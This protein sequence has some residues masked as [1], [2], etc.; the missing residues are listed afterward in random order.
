[1]AF[2]GEDGNQT[3]SFHLVAPCPGGSTCAEPPPEIMLVSAFGPITAM[4]C[5]FARSSGNIPRSFFNSTMLCSAM[6]RE[7]SKPPSTSTTLFLTGSSTIPLANSE[8]RIRSEEHTSELQSRLHLVCRLLLE[9][10]KTTRYTRVEDG[11]IP[12]RFAPLLPL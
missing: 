6:W 3:C 7:I 4:E 12:P 9:K 10:K 11:E 8:R 5:S 2:S 1:M